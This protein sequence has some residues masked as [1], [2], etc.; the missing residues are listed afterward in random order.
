M[1]EVRYRYFLNRSPELTGSILRCKASEHLQL[2]SW[3]L[4]LLVSTVAF[5]DL[6]KKG[7]RSSNFTPE[8]LHET[9]GLLWLLF[10]C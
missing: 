1:S 10:I 7:A 4:C 9:Q 6:A 5:P 2:K 3:V 8:I